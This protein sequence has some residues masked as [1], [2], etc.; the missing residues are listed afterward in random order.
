MYNGIK[1]WQVQDSESTEAIYLK[2]IL[3]NNNYYHIYEDNDV[4]VKNRKI[5]IDGAMAVC[6]LGW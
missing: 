5:L 1:Q 4:N 6:S 3:I 2:K